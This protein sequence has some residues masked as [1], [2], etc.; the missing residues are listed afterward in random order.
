MTLL[1]DDLRELGEELWPD[2]G[3]LRPH[4]DGQADHRHSYRTVLA[5]LGVTALLF[6]AVAAGSIALVTRG[7]APAPQSAQ[8]APSPTTGAVV[9]WLDA[10]ATDAAT[11]VTITGVVACRASDLSV[12]IHVTDPSYVGHGPIN[13]SFWEVSV[14]DLTS[15]PCFVTGTFDATFET[16]SGILKAWR[17]AL[18]APDIIYLYPEKQSPPPGFV[19]SALGEVGT[20]GSCV[21]PPITAILWSPGAGLG[22]VR[23]SPGPA[24]GSGTPCSSGATFSYGAELISS[25]GDPRLP[26][27][28]TTLAAP[29]TA[30]PGDHLHYTVTILN[31][32]S[33]STCAR[34]CPTSIPSLTLQQCPTYHEELEGLA[35]SLRSYTLNCAA[36]RP[37]AA[38]ATESFDMYVDVPR[39]ATP[40]PVVLLWALDE[41]AGMPHFQAARAY[42]TITPPEDRSSPQPLNGPSDVALLPQ[43][44]SWT[45]LA[46]G[47]LRSADATCDEN[48]GVEQTVDL[49]DVSDGI[50]ISF[51]A[52]QGGV[53]GQQLPARTVYMHFNKGDGPQRYAG[54]D[55]VAGTVTYAADGSS[56]SMDVWLAPDMSHIDLTARDFHLTGEWRCR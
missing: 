35:G 44:L 49:H 39:S 50:D 26:Q 22:S 15:K 25:S 18:P 51:V 19:S 10:P 43:S 47:S 30:S 55:A 14:S 53:Y 5:G 9:P 36:T 48:A 11:P 17:N 3:V 54:F 37:I 1:A 56:G 29:T 16:S 27:V 32:P 38:G 2:M 45:G 41:S 46:S 20:S 8:R 7:H 33:P 24:G 12:S 13:T 52:H 23:V 42:I 4:K 6:A 28:R 21:F 34:A 31:S 40:G